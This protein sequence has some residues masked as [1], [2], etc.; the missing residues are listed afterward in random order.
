MECVPWHIL[1][2]MECVRFINFDH[3]RFNSCQ[4]YEVDNE[5]LRRYSLR[6]LSVNELT[7]SPNLTSQQRR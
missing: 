1:S 2:P 6:T 3:E 7:D 4:I 5:D